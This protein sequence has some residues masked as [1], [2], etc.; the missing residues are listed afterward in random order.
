MPLLKLESNHK[1][2]GPHPSPLIMRTISSQQ[3]VAGKANKKANGSTLWI[4]GMGHYLATD[5]RGFLITMC[6]A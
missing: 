6:M 3:E 1:T 2:Q 5:T 4:V